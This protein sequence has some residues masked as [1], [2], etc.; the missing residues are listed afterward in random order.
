MSGVLMRKGLVGWLL[1][2][3]GLILLP[4]ICVL[5]AT[6]PDGYPAQHWRLAWV[7]VDV[8]EALGLLTTGWLL[9]RGDAKASFAAIGTATLLV[10]DAWFDVATAGDDVVSSLVLALGLELPLAAL[11][12]TVAWRRF[13]RAEG[14]LP[15]IASTE[16]VPHCIASAEGVLQRLPEAEAERLAGPE[17]RGDVE[18]VFVDDGDDGVAAGRRMVGVEQDRAA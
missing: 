9:R 7:G 13:Q 12:V 3:A 2:A 11:C 18:V 10:V 8:L 6:L 4:W 1:L 16:G 5:W 17:L 15:C 14:R